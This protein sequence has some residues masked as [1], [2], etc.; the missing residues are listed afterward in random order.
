MIGIREEFEG[1]FRA[2]IQTFSDEKLISIGKACA[3][4]CLYPPRDESDLRV[5]ARRKMRQ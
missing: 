2:R 5:E 4:K 3:W 1:D